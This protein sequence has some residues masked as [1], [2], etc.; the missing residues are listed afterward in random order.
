MAFSGCLCSMGLREQNP[1]FWR[2]VCTDRRPGS[3]SLNRW[4]SGQKHVSCLPGQVG[5]GPQRWDPRSRVFQG[6]LF[7]CWT[8]EPNSWNPSLPALSPTEQGSMAVPRGQGLCIHLS[9]PMPS[10]GPDPESALSKALWSSIIGGAWG[11]LLA[12]KH[13]QAPKLCR[14]SGTSRMLSNITSSVL[15]SWYCL[16]VFDVT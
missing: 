2:L 14:P 8:D 15:I 11:E 12:E 5:E 6:G 9:S 13:T 10:A 7:H 3:H 16:W 4:P 1:W